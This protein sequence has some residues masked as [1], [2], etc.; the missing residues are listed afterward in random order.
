MAIASVRW[1]QNMKF[2]GEVSGHEVL[3]DATPPF[4]QHAHPTPKELLLVSMSGCTAMDVVS[5]LKKHKQNMTDLEIKT[6]A[7]ARSAQP[8]VFEMARIDFFVAG[9]VD[10]QILNEAIH[11][12]LSKYCS[13]NAMLSKVV[14]L[15]WRS[16]INGRE[17]GSGKAEFNL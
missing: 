13:V 15:Q 9:E 4:G 14:S 10:S 12:S 3:M 17:V 1:Q 16:Y 5:L 11:L 8:Q 2:R 6:E 7:Q